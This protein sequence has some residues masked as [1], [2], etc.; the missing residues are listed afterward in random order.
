MAGTEEQLELPFEFIRAEHEP[1]ECDSLPYYEVPANDNERLLNYQYEF[2][3]G[4][5]NA[6]CRMYE[7]GCVIALKY[8]HKMA[9]KYKFM[10]Y[11]SLTDKKDVAHQALCYIIQAYLKKSNWALRDSF[12]GYL[13]RC[14]YK[15]VLP[16]R[17]VD[18]IVSFVDMEDFYRSYEKDLGLIE[19]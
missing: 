16:Q 9:K 6:L 1:V 7:L 12:T 15:F 8:V 2:R 19:K 10:R 13:Y 4:D 5:R 14:C 3:H 18:S 17:K 11:W